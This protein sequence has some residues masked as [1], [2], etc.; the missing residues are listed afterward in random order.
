[1]TGLASEL[2]ALDGTAQ[3]ELVR[4]GEVTPDELVAAAI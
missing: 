4:R 3:A 1:M 2:A